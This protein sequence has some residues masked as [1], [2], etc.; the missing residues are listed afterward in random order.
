MLAR[1]SAAACQII[2]GYFLTE[3]EIGTYAVAIGIIGFTAIA[4]SGG[5]AH[6]LPSIAPADFDQKSGRMLWWGF[7]FMFIGA[8]LTCAAAVALPYLPI[9]DHPPGLALT[10][11]ILGLRQLLIPFAQVARMRMTVNLKFRQ[12]AKLDIASSVIRLI[13]TAGLA[14]LGEGPMALVIPVASSTVVE[15]IYCTFRGGMTWTNYRWI[16]M[17]VREMA[18]LMALP[19]AI[20]A[21]FSLNSQVNFV[22]V[23]LVVPLATVGVFYFAFQLASQ[24]SALL[25][26]ALTNVFAPLVAR[27]RGDPIREAQMMQTF[28][29]G[30]MFFI[31]LVVFALVAAFPSVDRM[32]W[33][34]KWEAA[35]APV[36]FLAIGSSYGTVVAMLIG[37]LIGLRQFRA[38]LGFEAMKTIGVVGGAGIGAVAVLIVARMGMNIPDA[39]VISAGTGLAITVVSVLQLVWLM[40]HFGMGRWEIARTLWHGPALGGAMA[41]ASHAIGLSVS[42]SFNLGG[43]RL[44]SVVEFA[45]TSSLYLCI[46][47]LATRF[48]AEDTV[49]GVIDLLPTP[50]R[51]AAE[52]I[53]RIV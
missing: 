34:S 19:L 46:A 13:L 39:V 40:R 47:I 23:K 28:F 49:M 14:S 17:G 22:V 15:L 35:T 11:W 27:E 24:P 33:A 26:S 20:A 38:I 50:A 42:E 12:L 29:R 45:I 21:L 7:F 43:A 48:I 9:S 3:R 31:P 41:I 52:K 30:A 44:E 37:P 6:Y 53:F 4:R 18:K 10:L 1:V 36:I 5:T 32:I 51:R 8:T 16:G 2:V 25:S